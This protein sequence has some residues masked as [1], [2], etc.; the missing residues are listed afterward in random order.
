[1]Q[2]PDLLQTTEAEEDLPLWADVG[3]D[4]PLRT[5]HHMGILSAPGIS[6]PSREIY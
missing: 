6:T 4:W 1:M 5:S 3:Q 2:G